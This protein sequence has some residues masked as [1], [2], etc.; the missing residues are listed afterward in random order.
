MPL[1]KEA[2]RAVRRSASGLIVTDDRPSWVR[3]IQPRWNGVFGLQGDGAN[4]GQRPTR[5]N[6]L[7]LTYQGRTAAPSAWAADWG[8]KVQIDVISLCSKLS[9]CLWSFRLPQR[10][11]WPHLVDRQWASQNAEAFLQ[12]VVRDGRGRRMLILSSIWA[13]V[14]PGR[15]FRPTASRR[16]CDPHLAAPLMDRRIRRTTPAFVIVYTEYKTKVNRLI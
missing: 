13:P 16:P 12:C 11:F 6:K 4:H 3:F 14:P 9:P 7:L 5:W 1:P 10:N 2:I 8:I 15:S